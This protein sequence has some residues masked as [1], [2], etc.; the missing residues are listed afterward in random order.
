MTAAGWFRTIDHTA[1]VAIE[2][3][4]PDLQ[5]LFDRC[6]A[7]MTSLLAEGEA[8]LPAIEHPITAAGGDLPELLVDFLRQVLWLHVS[9]GFLYAAARFEHLA[10]TTLT[11][12]V[13][14]EVLDPARHTLVREIKAVTYHALEVSAEPGRCRA[15]IV[16]DV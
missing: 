6:A 14:G 7:G 5:A 8:P 10:D 12:I 4:A 2:A 9:T 1:D 16:F 3:G 11:G 15:R 13:R